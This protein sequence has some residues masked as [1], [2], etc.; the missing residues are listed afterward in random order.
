MFPKDL[1]LY[2]ESYLLFK[3]IKEKGKIKRH[4]MCQSSENAVLITKS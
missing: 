4:M 2:I 3:K 1:L